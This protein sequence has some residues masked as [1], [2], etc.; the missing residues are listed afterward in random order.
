MNT[1]P[2]YGSP[3]SVTFPG[4]S[5]FHCVDGGL[6]PPSGVRQL[7]VCGIP[8]ASVVQSKLEADLCM[9]FLCDIWLIS[10]FCSLLIGSCFLCVQNKNK[11]GHVL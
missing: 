3:T 5:C 9:L 4:H 2:A 10:L 6:C 1:D 7:L 11:F 8:G